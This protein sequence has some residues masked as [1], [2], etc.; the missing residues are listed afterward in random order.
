MNPAET[1]AL[2]GSI[3]TSADFSNEGEVSRMA[4]REALEKNQGEV[5]SSFVDIQNLPQEG[6]V[7]AKILQVLESNKSGQINKH[8]LGDAIKVVATQNGVA[9]PDGAAMNALIQKV[10]LQADSQRSGKITR[11]QLRQAMESNCVE[12]AV[13]TQESSKPST[14]PVVQ[15]IMEKLEQSS[16]GL[17]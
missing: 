4:I 8:D 5:T 9:Q 15:S 13:V 2:V 12:A 17:I 7:T 11:T 16:S 14:T 3:F 10:F 1:E 6:A